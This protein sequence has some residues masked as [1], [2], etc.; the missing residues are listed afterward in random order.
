ME[1]TCKVE[2]CSAPIKAKGYCEKHYY[3]WRKYGDPKRKTKVELEPKLSS[4]STLAYLLGT[5][6]GDGCLTRSWAGRGYNY[7]VIVCAGKS[8]RFAEY[9]KLALKQIGLNPWIYVTSEGEIK[10]YA[11][12]KAFYEWIKKAKGNK[13]IISK[14]AFEYPADFL[15]GLYEAE[16]GLGFCRHSL[17]IFLYRLGISTQASFPSQK[18]ASKFLALERKSTKVDSYAFLVALDLD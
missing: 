8:K 1:R 16:G 6:L 7:R 4:S 13:A 2:G 18:N 12:S 14:L 15:R 5:I 17:T 9:V 10:V 3:R 11:C